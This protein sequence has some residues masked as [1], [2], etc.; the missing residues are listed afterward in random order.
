MITDEG[1][2]HVAQIDGLEFLAI[3]ATRITAEGLAH[4]AV[5]PDLKVLSF[6]D[7]AVDAAAIEEFAA[8]VS[9]EEMDLEYC[10]IRATNFDRLASLS[11]LR[12]LH[13]PTSADRS[14]VERLCAALPNLQVTYAEDFSA[15]LRTILDDARAGISTPYYNPFEPASTERSRDNPFGD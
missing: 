4:L 6:R 2:Q 8:I 14:S 5:L 3:D 1:M 11:R 13:L 9:L 12:E 7:V 15:E 10:T